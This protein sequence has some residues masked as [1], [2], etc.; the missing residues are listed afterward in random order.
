[1]E[2]PGRDA[3]ITTKLGV[4]ARGTRHVDRERLR[5]RLDARPGGSTRARLGARRLRQ[6]HAARR[7]AGPGGRPRRVGV[8]RCA[9]QRRRPLRSLSR[10]GDGTPD[11]WNGG[12]RRRST[13]GPSIPTSP[14]PAS[15]TAS[16]RPD[17]GAVLVLDDYH[18][19]D[20]PAIH[21]L[22]ASL[23]ERLPPGA[24]LAIATRADP[25]L[26]LARLR[27]RGELLEVRAEDLRFT[28]GR[29]GRAGALD[30]R[31]APPGGGRGAHGADRG[32]GGRAAAGGGLAAWPVGPRRAGASVRGEPPLHPRLR[33][34]GSPRRTA[35]RDPGVPPAHLDPRPPV[36]SAVRGR[37]RRRPTARRGSRSWSART[38]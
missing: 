16:Q 27:A 23:V 38:C 2:M 3:L 28:R 37:R 5:A 26:P 7:L 35:A 32:L 1:M 10:P 21:R 36:R 30:R 17:D 11:G 8:A 25:P 24:R 18:V 20:E 31:R 13:P 29:G 6:E 12:H 34:R 19:I 22:V 14:W 4:Q 9:R 15:S 33:R